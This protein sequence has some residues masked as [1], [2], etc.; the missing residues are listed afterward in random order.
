[1]A[2]ELGIMNCIEC[3]SCAYECPSN[4]PLVQRIRIGKMKIN[5]QKNK[6]S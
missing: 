1:M 6:K 5:E 2:N 4:I 3:G